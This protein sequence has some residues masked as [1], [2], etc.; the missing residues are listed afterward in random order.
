MFEIGLIDFVDLRRDLQKK[1]CCA[2]QPDR[3]FR[4]F[5][6]ADPTEK[7]KIAIGCK[8]RF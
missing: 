4:T 7:G 1:V 2:G 3:G 8:T 5:L 6:R